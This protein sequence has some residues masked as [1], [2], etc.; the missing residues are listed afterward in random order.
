[1]TGQDA[2]TAQRDRGVEHLQ[3]IEGN[4]FDAEDQA[5]FAEFDG[6]GLTSEEQRAEIVARAQAA[7]RS[8]R[9]GAMPQVLAA[10]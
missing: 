8:A 1:M 7:D 9:I 6:L 3:E 4:P 5:M 2:T 10:E